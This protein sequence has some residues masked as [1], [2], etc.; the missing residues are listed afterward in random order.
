MYSL[1]FLLYRRQYGGLTA[2][3]PLLMYFFTSLLGPIVKMRYHYP[4]IAGVPLILY[5]IWKYAK[6]EREGRSWTK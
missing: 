6:I 1:M 2:L 4:L 5:L 3:L